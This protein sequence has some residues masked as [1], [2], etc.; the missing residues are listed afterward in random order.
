MAPTDPGSGEKELSLRS[1]DGERRRHGRRPVD[2]PVACTDEAGFR[3]E[4]VA[5]DAG[6]GGL[7]LENC[8][9]LSAGQRIVVT[10]TDIGTF[11]SRVMWSR[12]TRCGIQ[13]LSIDGEDDA[14]WTQSLVALLPSRG[15]PA[16]SMAAPDLERPSAGSVLW[17]GLQMLLPLR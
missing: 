1:A 3:W 10:L 4:A 12:G 6:L 7:G 2:W 17:R 15:G 16:A 5:V 13:F 14:Q 9:P 8:P 11:P